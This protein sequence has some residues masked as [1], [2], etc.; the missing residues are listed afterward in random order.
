MHGGQVAFARGVA[1]N[2]VAHMLQAGAYRLRYRRFAIELRLLR[3][4]GHAQALLDTQI[5]IVWLFKPAEYA[6]QRGFACAVPAN[7]AN[8]LV[9]FQ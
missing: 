8:P 4:K 2:Q 6:K 3:Y 9:G 1:V 5:A 7:E